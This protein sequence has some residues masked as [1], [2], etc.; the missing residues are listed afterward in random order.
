LTNEAA[1]VVLGSGGGSEPVAGLV[2][3][4]ADAFDAVGDRLGYTMVA[5]IA[6]VIAARSGD[7]DAAAALLGAADLDYD[8]HGEQPELSSQRLRA[9]A[10]VVAVPQPPGW[11][12]REAVRAWLADHRPA[13]S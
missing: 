8:R 13:G 1:A 3:Q 11:G 4:A 10:G 7:A 5:E 6:A 12:A 9:A 2:L